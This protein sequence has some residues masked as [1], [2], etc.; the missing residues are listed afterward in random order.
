MA[1]ALLSAGPEEGDEPLMRAGIVVGAGAS[2]HLAIHG[3]RTDTLLRPPVGGLDVHLTQEREQ[4]RSLLGQ[5]LEQLA[6]LDGV[7]RRASR[8]VTRASRPPMAAS[9]CSG[10]MSPA[11]RRSRSSGASVRKAFRIVGTVEWPRAL[12]S[13]KPEQRRSRWASQ[14]WAVALV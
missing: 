12:I 6:V 3:A 2:P 7:A 10:V 4:P 9:S 1:S 5:V 14:D 13:I 8:V 11:S